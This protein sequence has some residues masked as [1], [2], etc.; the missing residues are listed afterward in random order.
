[1]R[2]HREP[3]LKLP[4]KEPGSDVRPRADPRF[5]THVVPIQRAAPPAAQPSPQALSRPS[6][7]PK[8]PAFELSLPSV[9]AQPSIAAIERAAA[10]AAIGTSAAIRIRPHSTPPRVAPEA[11]RPAPKPAEPRSSAAPAIAFDDVTPVTS[12]DWVVKVGEAAKLVDV[13]VVFYTAAYL[14]SEMF[15]FA[16]RTVVNEVLP[17]AGRP[18]AIYRFS[19]DDEPGFVPEMAISLGLPADNPVTVAGFAWSGPGR[20][21]FVIGDDALES[22]AVFQRALRRR[23]TGQ[24]AEAQR[25]SAVR[26]DADEGVDRAH[27]GAVRPWSGRVLVVLAWCLFGTAALGAAVV[28]VA[29][30]WASSL[31]HPEVQQ[32]SAPAPRPAGSGDAQGASPASAANPNLPAGGA[33]STGALPATNTAKPVPTRAHKRRSA[34]S[35]P[36]APTYWGLPESQPR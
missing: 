36:A 24:P 14:G 1:M 31:L 10:A 34:T 15:K 16:F 3:W 17:K 12:A 11:A 21:L 6:A 8:E 2:E 4:A 18:Y 28:G 25:A 9:G 33:S 20:R 29:P 26:R 23:L 7:E 13:V 22:P 19:L 32:G 35:V 30:Q 5:R 27:R